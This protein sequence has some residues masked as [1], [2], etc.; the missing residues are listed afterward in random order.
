MSIDEPLRHRLE[1]AAQ[2]TEADVLRAKTAILET[3]AGGR[4]IDLPNLRA[5]VLGTLHLPGSADEL[6]Q[7]RPLQTNPE[8]EI[9]RNLPALQHARALAGIC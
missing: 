9:D 6:I 3:L 8:S 5:H 4:E 2:P 1:A 7:V